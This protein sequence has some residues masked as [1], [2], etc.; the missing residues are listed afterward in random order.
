MGQADL[1]KEKQL[2]NL[3]FDPANLQY[4]TLRAKSGS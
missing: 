2:E 3:N 1:S 4:F